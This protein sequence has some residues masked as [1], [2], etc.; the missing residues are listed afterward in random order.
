MD[1]AASLEN[2]VIS[3]QYLELRVPIKHA[4]PISPYSH[5]EFPAELRIRAKSEAC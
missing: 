2:R 5:A 1:T 3:V 4:H